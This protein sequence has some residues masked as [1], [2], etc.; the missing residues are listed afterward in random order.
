MP[1]LENVF[2]DLYFNL[3]NISWTQL[4]D[5]GLVTTVFFLLLNFLRRSRATAMLRGAL[6]LIA[7]FFIFTVFLP[8]PT[9]DYLLRF[10]LI[11]ILIATP[12]IFQSELRYG[13]E[14]LGRRV[15]ALTFRRMAGETTMKP[16]VRA[17]ENLSNKKIGALIVLE[18]EDDLGTILD[19]G[20]PLG[21]DVTSELLQTIFYEGTPLHDGALIIRGERAVAASCV[22]PVSNRQLYADQRRLGTRHRAAVGLAEV[23]DALVI[24]VSE[25]TGQISVARHGQLHANLEKTELREH[26]YSFYNPPEEEEEFS[27]SQLWAAL[28]G[29]RPSDVGDLELSGLLLDAPTFLL[30]LVLAFTTWAFVNQQTNPVRETR[31]ENI[32][33]R[34]SGAPPNTQ[35]VESARETVDAVVK[36][37]DDVLPTLGASSFQATVSLDGLEPGPRP[38]RLP[39]NV[40]SGVDRVQVVSVEPEMLDVQLAEII[41]RA[42]GVSVVTVGEEALS[43][44]YEI[45]D[46]PTATPSEVQ[47]TGAAPQVGRV[48]HARAEISVPTVAGTAQRVQSLVPV[49]ESGD[50][51]EGVM[52][53]PDQVQV[54]VTV[55]R[56][57]NARDVGVQ[58]QL[59][60]ELPEGYHLRQVSVSPLRVT[61]LGEA[62][63]VSG[64]GSAIQTLP[65]DISSV[66]D[67]FRIQVPL[68]L[69]PGV[70]A[71]NNSGETVRSVLVELDVEPRIGVRTFSRD[72]E[73]LGSAGLSLNIDPPSVDVRL[74]GPVPLLNE[75]ES[76][77]ELLRVIVDA[78]DLANL[79]SGETVTVGPQVA[80]P[81]QLEATLIP[82]TV[83]VT[84]E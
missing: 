41:T 4:L 47:V 40:E 16:L 6:V 76:A 52:L 33:L 35:L 9:F 45:R 77:P 42:V 63:D 7:L 51:V 50:V 72:V 56:R 14:Q 48:D 69:P 75:V 20:V 79:D 54:S 39:V 28:R 36:A 21:S 38:H 43:P 68:D 82:Q 84:A 8:L 61:L 66:S 22:L 74:R 24:V 18:G 17:L 13:L 15:G 59:S 65:L 60:G 57:P 11:A 73:V 71:L 25:E 31:I 12:V 49:D 55:A 44:A 64:V 70:E 2:S 58:V 53:R 37:T 19:T 80:K 1:P 46:A 10:A 81:E 32:P 29:W 5:L 67:D 62:E 30:A 26:I 27:F 3:A 34:V 23:S 83:S 78:A